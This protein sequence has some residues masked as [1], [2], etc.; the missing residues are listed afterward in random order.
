MRFAAGGHDAP[1]EPRDRNAIA[2]LRHGVLRLAEKSRVDA[3]EKFGRTGLRFD[4]GTVVDVLANRNPLCKLG[5]RTEMVAV[6]MR[7]DQVIDLFE[8]G[9]VDRGHHPIRIARRCRPAVARVD[10][11]RLAGGRDKERRVAAFDIEDVNLQ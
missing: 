6:P 7:R 3:A 2:R 1:V 5:H 9:S 11:H 4:C 8:A 10:Q